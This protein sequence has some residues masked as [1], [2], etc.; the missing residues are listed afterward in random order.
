MTPGYRSAVMT[1]G[2][3]VLFAEGLRRDEGSVAMAFQV[4]SEIR[5]ND[6]T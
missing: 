6:E 1:G 3:R 2:G 5:L 4:L